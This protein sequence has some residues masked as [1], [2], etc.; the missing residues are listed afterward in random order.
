VLNSPLTLDDCQAA[1]DEL[2]VVAE[3]LSAPSSWAAKAFIGINLFYWHLS[4][5]GRDDNPLPDFIRLCRASAAL[6]DGAAAQ[7]QPL[8]RQLALE[9]PQQGAEAALGELYSA[10]YATMDDDEY[11]RGSADV[12]R[13]RL[14]ANGVW[15]EELFAGKVVLDAGCGAGKFTQ[16]IA[17][18]GARKVIGID[19]GVGNIAF[20]RAQAEKVAHGKALSYSVSSILDIPLQA[21]SVDFVWCNSVAHLTGN[22]AQALREIGRVLKPGGQLFYYVNGR[23]GLFEILQKML[24]RVMQGVPTPFVQHFLQCLGVGAGRIS[25][26]VA[27]IFA[28]Y[29]FLPQSEV[30]EMLRAAGFAD[31]R[32][33]KRGIDIDYSEKIARGEPYADLKYGEGQLRYLARR[34]AP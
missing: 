22:Q 26:V 31:L 28:P 29:E 15:P 18:F 6:L 19:I 9:R 30:E 12:V 3:A 34:A 11:F 16:A 14:E 8:E 7:S 17:S 24:V 20:A 25:W 10:V 1:A 5:F 33:L 32:L 2:S 4:A 27:C 23:F 13:G 21:A